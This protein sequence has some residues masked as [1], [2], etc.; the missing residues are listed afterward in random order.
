MA[1]L[2]RNERMFLDDQNITPI[3]LPLEIALER[4]ITA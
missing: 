2:T 4:F 3:D 1:E